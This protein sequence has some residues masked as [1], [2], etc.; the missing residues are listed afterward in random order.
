MQVE[1]LGL[2]SRKKLSSVWLESLKG[3]RK[4]TS[5]ALQAALL[6]PCHVNTC[7][8]DFIT[9]TAMLLSSTKL[10]LSSFKHRRRRIRGLFTC[11]CA[12]E[13]LSEYKTFH[14]QSN[15]FDHRFGKQNRASCLWTLQKQR[16]RKLLK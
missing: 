16:K 11:P 12:A 1:K 2:I 4:V 13:R 14:S 9:F 15:P 3:N 7:S 10:S 8:E 5:R 6:L